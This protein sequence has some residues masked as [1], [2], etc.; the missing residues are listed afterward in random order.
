[1]G[2]DLRRVTVLPIAASEQQVADTCGAL[3]AARERT[4]T[5]AR[6]CELARAFEAAQ[7]CERSK[8]RER[9]TAGDGLSSTCARASAR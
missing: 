6:A 1:M 9:T 4:R 5:R 3:T 7:R 8:R 2:G